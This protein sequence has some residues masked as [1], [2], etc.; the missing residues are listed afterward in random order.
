VIGGTLFIGR[1]LVPEL[2]DRGVEVVIMH[3]GKGTP[4][5]NAVSEVRADRTDVE[6]VRRALLGQQFDTVYDNVYDWQRGTSAEQVTAAALAA[7]PTQRYVFTS[8]VAVYG[9]GLDRDEDE[10]LVPRM[11]LTATAPEADSERALFDLHRKKGLP[12]S[13]LRPSFIYGP[14]NPFE[15]EAFFWDR[16]CAGRP[17][18]VP[19]DGS[20]PMLGVHVHD[21]ARAA[22]LAADKAVANGRAYNLASPPIS[23]LDFVSLL[24]RVANKS[25]NVVHIAR[26][27]LVQKGGSLFEPPYY[28]GAYLDLRPLT[29]RT[30][31]VR[32]D[33]GLELTP[34]EDGM[35]ETYQWYLRQE[36]PRPDYSWED[37]VLEEVAG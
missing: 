4:F 25:A 1:A 18:I 8:S 28:F 34:L 17:I 31:R 33:L 20:R 30:E 15:R 14:H 32:K 19:D 12:V 23:Q 27:V 3:R 7:S 21:V 37:R 16:I 10:P 36:R 35:R 11:T 5:E 2:L 26:E 29:V 6:A 22:V 9:E 24:A 13:T